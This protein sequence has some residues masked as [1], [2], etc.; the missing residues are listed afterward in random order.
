ME[1]ITPKLT[2]AQAKVSMKPII[3]YIATLGND[4][5]GINQ[6]FELP[7]FYPFE[8]NYVGPTVEVRGRRVSSFFLPDV[9]SGS[10]WTRPSWINNRTIDPEEKLCH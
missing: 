9:S 3:D 2:P 1:F 5:T 10:G 7:S 6:V 8:A 4:I